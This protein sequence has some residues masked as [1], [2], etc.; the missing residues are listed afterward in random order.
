MS[1]YQDLCLKCANKCKAISSLTEVFLECTKFVDKTGEE[2]AKVELTE[3]EKAHIG[4]K[5]ETFI[6]NP[7]K[8]GEIIP[9]S[10]WEVIMIEI[11]QLINTAVQSERERIIKE[12]PEEDNKLMRTIEVKKIVQGGGQ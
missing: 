2:V 10:F 6:I 7:T 3:K 4:D 9:N 5:I 11:E 12:L 1:V 8:Q